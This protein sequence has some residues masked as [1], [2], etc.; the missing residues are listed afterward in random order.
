LTNLNR[1]EIIR[2]RVATQRPD[3]VI[4]ILRLVAVVVGVSLASILLIIGVGYALPVKHVAAR[5][6]VL[7]REPPE[8]FALISN[9]KDEPSWRPDV[10]RAELLPDENGRPRFREHSSQG[11]LTM[12]VLELAPPQRMVTQIDGKNL[13]FGGRWIFEVVPAAS[14]CRLN[15]TERGEI[16]NPVFRFLSR[17]AMGYTNTLDSYLRNVARK[18]GE[19][20]SPVDG[21]P[22]QE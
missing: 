19:T 20:S 7:R 1:A 15:I 2:A 21:E 14:G 11:S 8:V 3:E 12:A 13:P 5:A 10:L 17:F 16:Y 6:V 4:V 9:F 18:F 22:N